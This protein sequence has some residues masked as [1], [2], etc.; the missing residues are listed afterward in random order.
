VLK[1]VVEGKH[2]LASEIHQLLEEIGLGKYID[3]FAENEIDL[4]AAPHLSDDN[5]KELG[6]PMGPRLKFLAAINDR[7]GSEARQEI[8]IPN[9]DAQSIRSG[10]LRQVTVLFAD[11][12]G[13][14]ALSSGLD[15]EDTHALLNRFFAVVDEAVGEYGGSVDKHIGD[16]VMAVFGAPLAHTDD[17]ERTL[18][19][20]LDIHEAVAGLEPPLKVHIGVASGQ[21]VASST[22][23]AA[24][25]EYTVTG[26]SVNLA[27]RLTDMAKAGETLVSVSVQRALGERFVGIDLGDQAVDG[28]LEPVT[29]W[30]LDELTAG[31]PEGGHSFVGRTRELGQFA[32]ALAHSSETR[33]GQTVIVRG[34][35]GI[36]KTRLV[37]EFAGLAVALGYGVH[38]GLVLDF[39]TAKGQD[40]VRALVRS[41]LELP[42]GSTKAMRAEAAE[43]AVNG[44][45]VAEER[46]VHLNDLLDLQQPLDL[47]GLYQA[48]DN[49]TRNRGK[50]DAVGDLVRHASRSAP[51][52]LRVEDAHW[53]DQQILGHLAHL[54]RTVQ[55]MPVLLIVTTRI[56]GDRLDQSWRAGTEGAPLTT[57]DLG[58][59]DAS[60]ANAL[61]EDFETLD[62]DVIAACVERSGGNPLFLEQL[63]RNADELTAGNIPGTVQGIVQ[64][65]LDTLRPSDYEAIQ[66]A[67]VL[68][69]RFSRRAVE[70]LL[71]GRNFEPDSLLE[72]VLIRPAGHDYHFAHALI[73]DGVYASMLRPRRVELHRSA[74]DWYR[75][76]DLILHAEHL[77]KAEE[78]GAAS[79]YLEAAKQ[80][81]DK[82]RY[83]RAKV[84]VAH[85]LELDAEPEVR[86]HLSCLHGDLLRDLGQT[87]LS[88]AAFEGALKD[89]T[90]D[91][92][93]CIAN[94]GLAGGMRV[95]DR[96]DDAFTALDEAEEHAQ[97]SSLQLASVHYLRGSCYFP[98]G[99]PDKCLAEHQKALDFA[100]AAHLIRLEGQALSGMSDAL[101]ISRQFSR[102][103]ESL[104]DCLAIAEEHQLHSLRTTTLFMRAS[105]GLWQLAYNDLLEDAHAS[106][107]IARQIGDKRSEA[108]AEGVVAVG[109][110]YTGKFDQAVSSAQRS[111]TFFDEMGARRLF[112]VSLITLARTLFLQGQQDEAE[113]TAKQAVEVAR[114]RGARFYCGVAQGTL[115]LISQEPETKD[116]ALQDGNAFLSGP[117]H[118][119][120]LFYFRRDAAEIALD[121][122]DWSEALA[123]VNTWKTDFAVEMPPFGL[124]W[125]SWIKALVNFGK[126]QRDRQL[127]DEF[128]RLKEVANGGGV[129][130]AIPRIDAALAELGK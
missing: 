36:G 118:I 127:T 25:T 91:L 130:I 96:Y 93:I 62:A 23:S 77:D 98:L 60:E 87:D 48:M 109:Y 12:S 26:D 35:A 117:C 113:I 65:R 47:D 86:F 24:H 100:R 1:L 88:I 66:A 122:G 67:S 102:W 90:G 99:H 45:Q 54:T 38:T 63:L 70:A 11:I 121:A 50:Q 3:V 37:E 124:F 43:C 120:D 33:T 94:I 31:L 55:D 116:Q 126:G 103:R 19:A 80:Q 27:A 129:K 78:P 42:P 32:T 74:A 28:L 68:G 41:L 44:G 71:K 18:R 69:Q 34:E 57:V 107:A 85:A 52:L 115:A 14:T 119:T 49:E 128:N 104:D 125:S 79:A 101:Y 5:L 16:A 21:V 51:L 20:A 95:V 10:E 2:P 40:A 123:Q 92:Q 22:G 81:A 53:A 112:L 58:S 15:A 4:D 56:T 106:K 84:L 83:D 73:R 9:D 64:A 82:H 39:G 61:A 111:M 76:D 7:Q 46:R 6:L 89:A 29:V 105:S 110:Y 59:L 17:P 8:S 13:F 75:D 114:E 30:R 72:N 97:G 108:L